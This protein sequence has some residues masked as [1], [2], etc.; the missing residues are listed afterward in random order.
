MLGCQIGTAQVHINHRIPF[1]IG[2]ILERSI[3]QDA[4]IVNENINAAEC[5]FRGGH[6]GL[7]RGVVGHRTVIGD[8]PTA[9]GNDF[10]DHAVCHTLATAG[11]ITCAT[12]I[13]NHDR[14]PFAG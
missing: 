3:A 11:A 2:H 7:G 8:S 6:H 14:S 12:E 4:C 13:I 10:V 9:S 5:V 1:G